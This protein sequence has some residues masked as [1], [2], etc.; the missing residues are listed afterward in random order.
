M[1]RQPGLGIYLKDS[2]PMVA[3]VKELLIS[4]HELIDPDLA[5]PDPGRVTVYLANHGPF[6]A[7]FPAAVLMVDYLLGQGGYDDLVAVTLFH[8]IVEVMPGLAPLLRR[9]FGHSTRRLRTLSGVI[10][11]M[12]ERRFHLIGTAPEGAS[13]ML[14]YDEPVGPFTRLGLMVAALE[15]D[16]D[17]VLAAQ[18]GIEVFGRRVRLP[19]G[20]RLPLWGRPHG[21][22]VPVW[23][24]G[25]KAHVKVKYA[26]YQP[27]TS[28]EERAALDRAQR[29]ARYRQEFDRIRRQLNELYDAIP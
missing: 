14:A 21:L 17:I 9:Y 16:A 4:D 26:R 19:A 12:K 20:L 1:K 10:E 29:R 22:V 18:K 27:L 15:A 28:P 3:L 5:R 23:T 25:R 11:L 8:W 13:C 2:A 6:F 24:P 7:P